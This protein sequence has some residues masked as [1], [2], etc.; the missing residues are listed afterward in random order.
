M[1]LNLPTCQRASSRA[2]LQP[3]A[4]NRPQP[5]RRVIGVRLAMCTAWAILLASQSPLLAQSQLA[6]QNLHTLDNIR[7]EAKLLALTLEGE[8]NF[9]VGKDNTQLAAEQIV[10]WGAWT[11]VRDESAVWLADDSWVCGRLS[12]SATG[13]G[14]ASDWLDVSPLAWNAVRGLVLAPPRTLNNWLELQT[15]MLAVQGEEDVLWLTNGTRLTGIVRWDEA[16]DAPAGQTL[17]LEVGAG[18]AV[19]GDTTGQSIRI[20]LGEIKAIVFSPTLFGRVAEPPAALWISLQ[21]GS[22]LKTT[23]VDASPTGVQLALANGL[24]LKSLDF[25][26]QFVGSIVGLARPGAAGARF[27]SELHPASYRHVPDSSLRWELGV[28]RDVYGA[29]LHTSQGI[30]AGGLATHSVSQVAY[31]WDGSPARLLA[32]VRLAAVP[33]GAAERL[34]SVTC[35]IL[36]ARGGELQTLHEF[37]LQRVAHSQVPPVEL[38]S[39]AVQDAQ[40]IV[41]VTD[42][43]DYGQYGD[44]VLWLDARLTPLQK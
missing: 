29:D 19:V 35:R 4:V 34:G 21:D 40:L 23:R 30:F 37:D 17:Q 44:H 13:V 9:A 41:L 42:K 28:D 1:S 43:S 5:L 8:W 39:V 32:E 2:C 15:Q 10:R 12:L 22:H 11:G 27:L 36:V 25:T 24:Q 33:P 31:R 14:V 6:V 3:A 18:T 38:L 26:E 20:P 16:F 7:P